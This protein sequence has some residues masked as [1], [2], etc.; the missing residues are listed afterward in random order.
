MAI[1]IDSGHPFEPSLPS[2]NVAPLV[3][4]GKTLAEVRSAEHMYLAERRRLTERQLLAG[5]AGPQTPDAV[6]V[7]AIGVSLSGGGIRSATTNLGLLQALARM[8]LLP[9]VDY[10]CTVS[11]GGY[12]GGCLSALLSVND[13][14]ARAPDARSQYEFD[15]YRRPRF[16]TAP[17]RFPFRDAPGPGAPGRASLGG[18]QEVKHLRTHGS[19]LV[20]RK[21]LFTTETL[22]SVGVLL[23]GLVFHWLLYLLT[24]AGLAGLSLAWTIGLLAPEAPQLIKARVA[25]ESITIAAS[26]APPAAVAA[27]KKPP[28]VWETMRPKLSLFGRATADAV[29]ATRADGPSPFRRALAWGAIAALVTFGLAIVSRDAPVPPTEGESREDTYY[30]LLLRNIRRFGFLAL[31]VIVLHLRAAWSTSP[32]G[33]LAWLLLPVAVGLGFWATAFA[34]YVLLPWMPFWSRAFRAAWGSIEA[35]ATYWLLSAVAL[36]LFPFAVYAIQNVGPGAVLAAIVTALASRILAPR[37]GALPEVPGWAWPAVKRI[38]LAILVV[39]FVVLTVLLLAAWFVSW[40][41]AVPKAWVPSPIASLATSS[42][43]RAPATVQMWAEAFTHREF[44]VIVLGAVIA[45]CVVGVLGNANRLALHYFYRDRLM[46]TY[47]RTEA[48]RAQDLSL[49]VVHDA[50]G[51]QL[52]ELHGVAPAGG[53]ARFTACVSS[54][55]YLVIGAAINLAERR[56]LTRKDRK[57]GYFT[58]SKLYCGSYHTSFCPTEEYQGGKVNLARAMTISGAAVGSGMGYQT[59]FAQAFAATLFNLRLGY[60]MENPG[61]PLRLFRSWAGRPMFSPWYL[62]REMCAWTHARGRLVN[63]SDGGHTGDNVGIYP[64]LQRRCRVIIACDAEA[65][66]HLSFGSFTEALRHAYIDMNIDVDIDLTMIRPD[67]T[68]GLSRTHCAVGRIKYPPSPPGEPAAPTRA[69]LIYVKSSLSGDEPEPL[70]NYKTAHGEFPHETTADQFFTDAQFESYRALGDHLAEHVFGQVFD[71]RMVFSDAWLTDL[72]AR[73][74]S[75]RAGGDAAR[76]RANERLAVVEDALTRD[77]AIAW[78]YDQCYGGPTAA[79]VPAPPYPLA[80]RR[81][82]LQQVRLME[83]M[84]TTLE[85]ARHPNAPDNR[86]WMRLFRMWASS[87][88]FRALFQEVEGTMGRDFVAFYRAYLELPSGTGLDE[89]VPHP[90]DDPV[91]SAGP[92]IYLDPGR[93]EAGA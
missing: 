75:V 63:L 73:H 35:L 28:G 61:K 48:T 15:G 44:F 27:E 91:P 41:P 21:G 23:S 72:C 42:L 68:T 32:V 39:V 52:K 16:T 45:L 34:L 54:A 74:S 40:D 67:P 62:F 4:A 87:P 60:W 70:K 11:G 84:F 31:V 19:F 88:V 13:D 29:T 57:S 2:A 82:F 33:P 77:P 24:A 20:V 1:T 64:L 89:L 80:V 25:S 51:I 37:T 5:V 7:S 22:R 78:Y 56:D 83:Q 14:P 10:L 58:F 85:L 47:L 26:P 50:M 8:R 76:Q 17:D 9:H 46:E 90:W 53:A 36:A 79:A 49:E 65:D 18:R 93:R 12:I 86:G 66:P 92:R 38:L 59:F 55:P 69:W 81:A 71:R 30:R 6:A 43:A 3:H